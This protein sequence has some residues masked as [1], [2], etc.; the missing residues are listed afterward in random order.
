VEHIRF[1][2][3]LQTAASVGVLLRNQNKPA[4]VQKNRGRK[5]TMPQEHRTELAN[6]AVVLSPILGAV[7]VPVGIV[8]GLWPCGCYSGPEVGFEEITIDLL[9]ARFWPASLA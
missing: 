4:F 1:T 8:P 3:K 9:Q 5:N 7:E 6:R 2:G